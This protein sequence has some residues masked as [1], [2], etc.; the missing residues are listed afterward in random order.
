MPTILR[1]RT[2]HLHDS[3]RYLFCGMHQNGPEHSSQPSSYFKDESWASNAYPAFD[4]INNDI[5]GLLV[6]VS[7]SYVDIRKCTSY[8]FLIQS[9]TFSLI[10]GHF[11][12]NSTYITLRCMLFDLVFSHLHSSKLASYINIP[13][14]RT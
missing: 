12:G 2:E 1:N 14:I 13:A 3:T 5:Y 6:G 9:Y 7:L 10:A 8:N 4:D 11:F